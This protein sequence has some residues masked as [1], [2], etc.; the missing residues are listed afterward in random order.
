M[1]HSRIL[2]FS[3]IFFVAHLSQVHAATINVATND[4]G[5]GQAQCSLRD[6]IQAANTDAPSG[7]CPAGSGADRIMIG[8]MTYTLNHGNVT[9][10]DPGLLII[11]SEIA[12][13]GQEAVIEGGRGSILKVEDTSSAPAILHATGLTIQGADHIGIIASGA[14]LDLSDVQVLSNHYGG[15]HLHDA[16]L[17]LVN[18]VVS[19]NSGIPYNLSGIVVE[20]NSE[21]IIENSKI[22]NNEGGIGCETC[23]G[24]PSSIKIKNSIIKSN[25]QSINA[26]KASLALINTRVTNHGYRY[27]G[28]INC[29]DLPTKII[30]STIS[31]NRVGMGASALY[32]GSETRILNST[33]SN[34]EFGGVPGN[35]PR[36]AV[37]AKAGAKIINSTVS[38]NRGIGVAGIVAES[39][40][41]IISSTIVNN[42]FLDAPHAPNTA[43]LSGNVTL[44]NTIISNNSSVPDCSGTLTSGSIN[45]LISDGSCGATLS[46][47]PLIGPL[48]DNGGPTQTHALLPESAAIDAGNDIYCPGTDQRG[49]PRPQDG[50]GDGV[51]TCDIG[52]FELDDVPS[53]CDIT[54]SLSNNKWQQI[55]LPCDPGENNSVSAVFGDD[56]LAAYSTGWIL[57][58]YDNSS[59]VALDE[60]DTLSQGVGYWIIQKSGS[61]VT[62]DMPDNSSSTP[63]TSSTSC[64]DTAQGY[65]AIPLVTQLNT[66]QWNMVGYPF[67]SAGNLGKV[68]VVTTPSPCTLYCDLD[69]AE[70]Q[71]IVHNQFWNYDGASYTKVDTGGNLDP[72]KGYWVSTLNQA[73]GT[74]PRLLVPKP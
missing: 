32:A 52:A 54:Y 40:V 34:N 29:S 51:S 69:E 50:D 56:I 31:G 48:A 43:G 44:I 1:Y 47:A 13:I 58:R 38:G 64:L 28:A 57:Y 7:G 46:G 16:K 8:S 20:D 65:F 73:S 37:Y 18:S 72:W 23:N 68:R 25:G 11:S 33:I 19:K 70:S 60:T 35:L 53:V 21:A 41:E 63:V 39:G 9:Q 42:S 61:E 26:S 59:Y 4:P 12:L 30:N 27:G 67:A 3:T 49:A 45:N 55:S 22:T 36:P 66:T 10:D 14:T 15:I 6:A 17:L 71:G 74:S 5:I 24:R 2:W 62:L